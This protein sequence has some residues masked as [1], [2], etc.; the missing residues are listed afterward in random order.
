MD[1]LDVIAEGYGV[2]GP[3]PSLIYQRAIP[4]LLDFLEEEGVRATFFAITD[5]LRT[6]E[7]RRVLRQ[8]AERGHE[9][10]SHSHR[11]EHLFDFSPRATAEDTWIS[12]QI[13]GN[14]TGHPP[15][16]YRA[17]S[18]TYNPFVLGELE[19]LGYE[20]D[21][22]VHPTWAFMGEWIYCYLRNPIPRNRPRPFYLRHACA[23]NH[24]YPVAPPSFFRPA[25]QGTLVE[26]PISRLPFLGLPYYATFHFMFPWVAPLS[27]RLFLR[28]RR[29]TFLGHALDFL[30]QEEDGLPGRL[31][32]HPGMRLP[33]RQ[34]AAYYRRLI[35]LLTGDGGR[36]V[37]AR[38]LAQAA[39]GEYGSD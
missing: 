24:P 30:S 14:V 18:L 20:Y 8:V 6:D 33:W 36:M 5:D 37:T 19:R 31:A 1:G 34:K 11:H 26:L 32:L 35:G 16:G 7:D 21:S 39:R 29:V 27:D 15:K 4:R 22:S 28:N 25:R 12:T 2:S 13:I 3:L 38:E 23:P 17:A 10:G 9:V